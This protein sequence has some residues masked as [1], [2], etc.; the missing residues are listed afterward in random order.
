M[1]R[2][3]VV[4]KEGFEHKFYDIYANLSQALPIL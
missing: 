3:D 4:F 2:L 1:N